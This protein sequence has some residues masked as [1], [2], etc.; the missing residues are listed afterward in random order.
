MLEAASRPAGPRRIIQNHHIDSTRWDDFPLRSDDIIIATYGKAGTTWLQQIV[1]QLIFSGDDSL[2]FSELSP[3]LDMRVLPKEEVFAGLAAQENRRFIKTHLPFDALPWSPT[4]RYLYVARDVRDVIWSLHRFHANM[5]PFFLDL[6]NNTPGRVGNELP[7]VDPDIRRY[8]RT[9]LEQDGYPFWA[10]WSH[11]QSWWNVRHLPNV[12]LIHFN[13]LK[14]DMAGEIRRIADFLD[15]EV[16]ADAWPRVIAHSTFD[17]MKQAAD[18]APPSMMNELFGGGMGALIHKG[19]NGR[20]KDV[21]SRDEVA[22]ADRIAE[23]HLPP[24]CAQW[25]KTGDLPVSA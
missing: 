17:W 5:T 13:N 11:L 9:F 14:A 8:Y 16:D 25:L 18:A 2:S 19:T 15:I 23:E 1:G 4:V 3:W 21:L 20:W 22:L 7:P 24:D 6:L 10:F 12:L